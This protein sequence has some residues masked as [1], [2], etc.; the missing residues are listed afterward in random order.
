[1]RCLA[2]S[3]SVAND[4]LG[5]FPSRDFWCLFGACLVLKGDRRPQ[6]RSSALRSA[7][8]RLASAGNPIGLRRDLDT[9]RTS[10]VRH[11]DAQRGTHLASP[12]ALPTAVDR[13]SATLTL[14]EPVPLANGAGL[15]AGWRS[16]RA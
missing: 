3:P 8:G 4:E 5:R 14:R 12:I 9:G 15:V 2:L 6:I 16:G 10:A 7:K 13:E 1:E 11:R